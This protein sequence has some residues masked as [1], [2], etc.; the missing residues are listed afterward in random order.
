MVPCS[1]LFFS[2]NQDAAAHV[3]IPPL[4]S[5]SS[6]LQIVAY[7]AW[8]C[9]SFLRLISRWTTVTV[10]ACQELPSGQH[11]W[12]LRCQGATICVFF[13]ENVH[14]KTRK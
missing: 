8:A 10:S 1:L 11:F 5:L 14:G 3:E 13:C 9:G 7:V 2:V 4:S 6:L 12:L